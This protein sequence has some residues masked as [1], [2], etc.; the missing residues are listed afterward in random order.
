MKNIITA[1]TR[2][3]KNSQTTI[4]LIIVSNEKK[5]FKSGTFEPAISDHK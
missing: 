5:I 4:D 1:P 2:V 3:A